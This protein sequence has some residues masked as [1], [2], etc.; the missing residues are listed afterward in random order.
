LKLVNP[1]V[2]I[3]G[4]SE[5][6]DYFGEDSKMVAQKLKYVQTVFPA[7]VPIVCIGEPLDIRESGEHIPWVINQLTE[8]LGTPLI[9]LLKMLVVAY[10]PKWAIGRDPATP[11]QAQ[12]M[13]GALRKFFEDTY[14]SIAHAI[15]IIYGGAAAPDNI[16]GFMKCPDV[17]GV[18]V[19]G[20]S[21]TIRDF[22][23][24]IKNGIAVA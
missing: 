19:G 7:A 16:A 5:R 10:E 11:E 2:V 4:H 24:L 9:D 20:Y 8:S 22:V 6:R 23:K 17:D 13:H 21:L 14:G 15:R 3:L 18:L 12:E 1:G